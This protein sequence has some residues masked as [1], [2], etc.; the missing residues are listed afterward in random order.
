MSPVNLLIS[1]L[2]SCLTIAKSECI[3]LDQ[4]LNCV[5]FNEEYGNEYLYAA[6]GFHKLALFRR[7]VYTWSPFYS[8]SNSATVEK[9]KE[10]TE[11]DLQGVWTF[12]RAASAEKD[13]F[14]I[15]NAEFNEYLYASS[16][17]AG[18]TGSRRRI[19]TWKWS[20]DNF[21][22]RK[23][24]MWTLKKADGSSSYHIWNVN[25]N[26]PLYAGSF[27]QKQDSIRRNVYTW[28]TAPDSKQF[29]WQ[30]KCKDDIQLID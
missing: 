6:S 4:T 26:Q 7:N 2:I 25:Y 5:I 27:W 10:Y 18:I 17:H 19:Y 28:F 23:A 20:N 13:T 21:E 12:S 22:N 16:T 30:I 15:K 29:N 3:R 9:V 24:F 1:L 14:F 8:R 11:K